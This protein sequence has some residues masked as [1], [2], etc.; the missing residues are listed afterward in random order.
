MSLP[1]PPPLVTGPL[2]IARIEGSVD[3]IK[4]IMYL[5]F[6][7]HLPLDTQTECLD[8]INSLSI[9]QHFV[10]MFRACHENDPNKKFDLFVE[11]HPLYHPLNVKYGATGIY[12]K[13]VKKLL[14]KQFTI[15]KN[16]LKI[17]RKNTEDFNNVRL[18][19]TDF[20]PI[21]Y[22]DDIEDLADRM[23][24][25]TDA[26]PESIMAK[27]L[28]LLKSSLN[29]FE[30]LTSIL[31]KS[32]VEGQDLYSEKEDKQIVATTYK[33]RD[34]F[35]IIM[36]DFVT[37]I[38]NKYQHSSVKN[39]IKE[40]LIDYYGPIVERRLKDI[41]NT[42]KDADVFIKNPVFQNTSYLYHN[43]SGLMYSKGGR[44]TNDVRQLRHYLNKVAKLIGEVRVDIDLMDLYVLRRFLDKD[45]IQTAIL[46]SGSF[47]SINTIRYLVKYFDFKLTHLANPSASMDEINEKIKASKNYNELSDYF[48]PK[49]M[50]QCSD[51]STFPKY[52]E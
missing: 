21:F 10:S 15:D 44:T 25:I 52:Y 31:Y 12:I 42:I 45:Y 37:K 43:D 14:K 28:S 2:N 41:L 33:K 39:K 11:Y 4:K 27:Q 47:H 40:I 30:N 34:Y 22:P 20:R 46:Y 18:H 7:I 51:M 26:P 1:Y 49:I 16:T 35:A 6:D 29:V 32:L 23:S 8:P 19:Y 13:D 3:G 38:L 50:L 9:V 36:R 5:Y 17:I 48:F 24:N